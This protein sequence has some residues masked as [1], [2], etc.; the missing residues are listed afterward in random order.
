MN[1]VIQWIRKAPKGYLPV[2]HPER[3][4]PKYLLK[5]LTFLLLLSPLISSNSFAEMINARAAVGMDATTGE[6]FYAKNPTRQLAPASTTKLM[7]AILVIEKE[8]F[9]K[10]VTI[11][12]NASNA[13]P[14]KAGFKGGDK[15]TVEGLLYAALLES[16]NDAA[17]A[18][19][20]TVA[21]SEERFVRFMNEKAVDIG[22]SNTKFINATGLPGYG[23]HT[24]AMD[25]S[26]IMKYAMGNFALRGIIQTLST[27]VSTKKGETLF[28]RNT[29][30]LL[31]SD[32]KVIGGKTGFT[33]RAQHCF[34]C[35]AQDESKTIIIAL[36]GSPSRRTLWNDAEK[37][38]AKGF[39]DNSFKVASDESMLP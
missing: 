32:E 16:A 6:I 9:S 2:S 38:I 1:V 28:L 31:W 7:T 21:G 39:Q 26:I 13:Q 29:D 36:L 17:V 37:L 8:I 33:R 34:V 15:V 24:T 12:K 27:E 19:A 5:V 3:K 22:A 30:K 25:L 35:A 20:E 18:L 4:Q 10:V 11:S 14:A 23:Q